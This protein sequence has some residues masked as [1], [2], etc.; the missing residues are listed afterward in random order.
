[1]EIYVSIIIP[2]YNAE[3][4]ILKLLKRLDNQ[5]YSKYEVIV[6]DDGSN[7]N[8]RKYVEEFIKNKEKFKLYC[9]ENSGVSSARNLGIVKSKG[10]YI[11]FIDADDDIFDDSIELLVNSIERNESDFVIGN[12]C[13]N[14]ENAEKNVNS[15]VFYDITLLK[16][17]IMCP[18]YKNTISVYRLR[19]VWGKLYKASII[20]ENNIK[21]KD[22][23]KLF[24]DGIFNLDYIRNIEKYST[25]SQC[26]Y[27]YNI[28][29]NSAVHKLYKDINEIN[30]IRIQE[31]YERV[32]MDFHNEDIFRCFCLINFE[33]LCETMIIN[34]RQNVKSRITY[35]Q[36]K[37]EFKK[38]I[39][40]VEY[41]YLS[42]KHRIIYFLIYFKMFELIDVL[43]DIFCKS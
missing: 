37:E 38:Y 21:F 36:Y 17:K 22:G 32:K 25:L 12:Y 28:N 2:V 19:N 26:V 5:T 40:K 23:L 14:Y 1:M 20:R 9:E 6:I 31:L 29:E 15:G 18:E 42:F 34:K 16:E 39:K 4:N 24:E 11:T 27:V 3:K 13:T 43:I 35:L 30:N 10:K 7:D 8:T 33:F 41:R